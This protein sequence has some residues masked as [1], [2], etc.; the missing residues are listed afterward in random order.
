MSEMDA[1]LSVFIEESRE[2]L[3][4]LNDALLNLE[5]NPEDIESI[6]EIFRALHTLKGMAGTM[7]FERLTKLCHRMEAFLDILRKGEIK[8]TPEI[9]DRIFYGVDFISQLIESIASSGSEGEIDVEDVVKTFEDLSKEETT[10]ESI[11]EEEQQAEAE[12]PNEEEPG[13]EV[14]V[15][16]PTPEV[17]DVAKKATDQGFNVFYVK[18]ELAADTALKF[19]RMYMVFKSIENNGGEIIQTEPD[20]QAIEEEKFDRTVELIVVTKQNKESLQESISNISEIERV[21]V[22]D[23]KDL[24]LSEKTAKKHEKSKKAKTDTETKE[25]APTLSRTVR[26]DIEKLDTL[27]NLMGELVIARSRI[28]ETLKRYKVKEVDESLAQLSRTT[29]DLQNVVMKIRMIPVAFVFNRF[30]RMVRDLSKELG[31]RV[32]L[33]ISGQETELDRTVVDQIGEPLVH[34][35]RNAIDHGIETPEERIARGKP[36]EGRLELTARQEGNSVIIEVVDDGRGFDR[37]AIQRKAIERG[38]LDEQTASMMNDDEIFQFVFHPGFSTKEDAT[39]ISGR[40]VG[41]DVVKTT[42]ESLNGRVAIHSEPGKGTRVSVILPLTLAII[43]VLLVRVAG[44]IYAFPIVSIDSVM[45]ISP[46]D[47]QEI[48]DREVV[49]SRGEI[50]P[51]HFLRRI[52]KFQEDGKREAVNVVVVKTREGKRGFVVDD[53][54]GQEDIVIKSLGKLL[55]NI[56]Y[57]GGGAILGDGSIALIVDVARLAS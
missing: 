17:L 26:V 44:N 37:N 34:L 38:L 40:G 18:V 32:N 39:E 7:G 43:Q 1:Y 19:P 13:E 36:A 52:F 55:S 33:I 41:M 8:V 49:V 14:A 57:F 24:S 20:V 10:G 29:L 51:V 31:K 11:A 3:Q 47:I 15:L 5:R 30:P 56:P 45:K 21:V 27:M 4:E 54:I 46:Q 9:V 48:Q 50:I 25:R 22:K 2:H 23:L 35:I 16:R 53:L 42:I 6:N 12:T 28:V